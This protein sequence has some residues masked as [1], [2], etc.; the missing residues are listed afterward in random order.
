MN[1]TLP[2]RENIELR[3]LDIA[4]AQHFFDVIKKNDKHLRQWLGWL[5]D[6]KTV[7]DTKKYIEESNKRFTEKEGLDLGIFYEGNHVG[8]IGLFPWDTANKKTS[9]VYWLGEEF[10]GKGIMVDSM[11]VVMGYAF[12]EMKL[13]RIEITCAIGNTKSSALPKKLGFTFEGIAREAGWLYD[14]F[15]DLEVYALLAKE[16]KI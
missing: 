1:L 4:D 14:Y 16:W 9:V 10:Q 13:N 5:D 12:T 11:K 8:G 15:V 7:A 6:D 3:T 2:V